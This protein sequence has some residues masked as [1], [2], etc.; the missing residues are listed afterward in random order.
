MSSVSAASSSATI[1]SATSGMG[2]AATTTTVASASANTAAG[3][4]AGSPHTAT[5]DPGTTGGDADTGVFL[6]Q[7]SCSHQACGGTIPNGA[8]RYVQACVTTEQVVGP[9]QSFCPS[10]T[11]VSSSG[12]LAGTISFD[13]SSVNQ[14]VSFS[15]TIELDVP[16]D[17]DITCPSFAATLAV[18]GFP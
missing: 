2:G 3:G 16:A 10:I 11:L 7:D 5:G 12:E 17:C 9:L 14:E 18:L 1:A 8:W 4:A 15:L 13:D 6:I